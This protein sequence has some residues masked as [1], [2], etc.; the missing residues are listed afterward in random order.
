[1]DDPAME[2]DL[3]VADMG[4]EAAMLLWGRACEQGD[5]RGRWRAEGEGEGA[6]GANGEAAA[7]SDGLGGE[8]GESEEAV[9]AAPR[10]G[11]EDESEGLA[12]ARGKRGR[13]RD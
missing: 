10:L 9:D 4:D 13:R 6:V 12:G 3:G 8:V 1:M 2:Q 7:P 11:G 5:V